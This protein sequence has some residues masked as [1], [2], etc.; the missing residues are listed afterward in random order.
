[1]E[2]CKTLD[3]AATAIRYYKTHPDIILQLLNKFIQPAV[4]PKLIRDNTTE[5]NKAVLESL[6]SVNYFKPAKKNHRDLRLQLKI[7]EA[8]NVTWENN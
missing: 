5:G 6:K 3:C 2:I 8:S 7:L 4:W 1:M